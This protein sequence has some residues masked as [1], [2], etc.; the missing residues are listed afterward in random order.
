[1]MPKQSTSKRAI[2]TADLTRD[3]INSSID[4]DMAHRLAETFATVHNI[5]ELNVHFIERVM[6]CLESCKCEC[7]CNP[8]DEA[9]SHCTCISTMNDVVNCVMADAYLKSNTSK[10]LN[11]KRKS[12]CS[13]YIPSKYR[14]R[15]ESVSSKLA[16]L[17]IGGED[18]KMP[19]TKNAMMIRDD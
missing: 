8:H 17:C 6:S 3:L 18:D 12:S 7:K 14:L 19:N 11:M 1:M 10:R 9:D 5:P 15:K 4:V 16:L 2:D 13:G